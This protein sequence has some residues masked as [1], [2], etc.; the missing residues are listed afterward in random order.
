MKMN[1]TNLTQGNGS[2]LKE[3]NTEGKKSGQKERAKK[4][5]RARARA[6]PQ[7]VIYPNFVTHIYFRAMQEWVTYISNHCLAG[8]HFPGLGRPEKCSWRPLDG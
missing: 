3:Y 5:A 6:K 4:R 8:G 2:K 7:T 1:T